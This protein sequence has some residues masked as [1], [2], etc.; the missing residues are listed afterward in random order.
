MGRK[1]YNYGKKLSTLSHE[2]GV[3]E[4]PEWRS[5]YGVECLTLTISNPNREAES[6]SI[7]AARVEAYR[8]REEDALA[9]ARANE[10]KAKTTDLKRKF[11]EF[12]IQLFAWQSGQ[13]GPSIAP[14][15][16]D[17]K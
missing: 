9:N 7:E 14:S 4:L 11:E 3:M 16:V 13:A 6:Q 8:A 17:H 5:T 12:H 10:A 15:S 2:A 1:S